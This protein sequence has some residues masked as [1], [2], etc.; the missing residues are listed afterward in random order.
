MKIQFQILLSI[1]LLFII[2]LIS[3]QKANSATT[4]HVWEMKEIK[5]EAENDY[6]NYY[7]DVTC[8]IEL[9]GP[10]FSK[11]IYGFWD[12]DNIYIVR[13]VATKPGK[14]E[15]TSGSNQPDDNGL[16]GQKGEFTAIDW[17]EEEKQQNPNRCG[18]IRPT[19]NGHALQYDDGT[20]HRRRYHKSAIWTDRYC[21]RCG[22]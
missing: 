3:T 2:V 13:I 11:R 20:R 15:W 17:T 14:W 10:D 1:S 5:L 18:F 16:N 12:G 19:S 4:I 21:Y 22:S 6:D 8:W 9:T 7:T